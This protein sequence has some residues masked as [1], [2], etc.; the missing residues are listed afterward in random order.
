ME[1]VYRSWHASG[2][3]DFGLIPM[4]E[5]ADLFVLVADRDIEQTILGLPSRTQALGIRGVNAPEVRPF[6]RHDGGCRVEGVALLRALRSQFFHA[7]LIFDFDGSGADNVTAIELENRQE[8]DLCKA[9]WG[10]D[11]AV[12]VI[13]PEIE[14]WVWTDSSHVD[15]ILGWSNDGSLRKW[16]ESEGFTIGQQK[17]SDPKQAMRAALKHTRKKPSSSI[18]RQLAENVRFKGCS[19][20]SFN[21]LVSTLQ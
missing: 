8:S 16:L 4:A 18:F 20:R 5:P 3:W 14:A 17:P 19:D 6:S 7:L 10:K 12:I 13:E 15:R 1:E 2:L 11:A 21:K 9:G